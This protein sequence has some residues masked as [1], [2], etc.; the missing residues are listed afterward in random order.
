[1]ILFNFLYIFCGLF[2]KTS[3]K[4]S[5]DFFWKV[6]EKKFIEFVEEYHKI[7][8]NKN[9][10]IEDE[11]LLKKIYKWIYENIQIALNFNK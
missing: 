7:S 11:K 4:Q 9:F 1:M 3:T 2:L 10:H 5:K 8:S 6:N